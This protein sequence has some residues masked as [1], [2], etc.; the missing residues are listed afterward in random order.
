VREIGV[1]QGRLLPQVNG[2]IQAFPWEHWREEF[3]LAR[4]HGFRSIEFIFEAE[5]FE[6]NPIY[7]EAGIAE[8]QRRIDVTGVPVSAIC[9]DYFMDRPFFRVGT[10]EREDSVRVLC[11]LIEAAARIGAQRVEIPCV[12]HASIQTDEDKRSLVAFVSRCFP[13]AERCSIEVVFE[14]SLPP[15]EFRELLERFSHPLVRANYDTGNSASLGYDPVQE[16]TILGSLVANIHIK[17][18]VFHGCTVPLGT[19]NANFPAIFRTLAEIRYQ[20]PFILQTARD[21]DDIGAAVRYRD[22]A[23]SYLVEYFSCSVSES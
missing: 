4:Q 16:L 18:R 17:D 11:R 10:Q 12:D 13:V 3:E 8:I 6:R 15:E 21:Q 20:G 23:Q 2:R 1:M 22:M 5:G 7:T 14:T 9:A 19:G